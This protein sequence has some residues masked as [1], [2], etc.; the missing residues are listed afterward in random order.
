MD[1]NKYFVR[2]QLNNVKVEHLIT[3]KSIN[4]RIYL[5]PQN[6]AYLKLAAFESVSF[7]MRHE[8]Q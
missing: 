6:Y 7:L 2:S 5:L 8:E 3:N 1:L 4:F